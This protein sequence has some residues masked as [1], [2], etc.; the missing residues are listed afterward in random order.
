MTPLAATPAEQ[1]LLY[2]AAVLLS[3]YGERTYPKH[4]TPSERMS[5]WRWQVRLCWIRLLV[6]TYSLRY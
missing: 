2:R 4:P 1:L 5:Y 3:V 6:T